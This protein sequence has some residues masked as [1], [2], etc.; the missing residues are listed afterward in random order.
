DLP[1]CLCWAN[2]NWSRRWDGL[3]SQILIGQNHSPEDD[4]AFIEHIAQYMNDKRYIRINGKPLLVIYRPSLLPDPKAT[5]TRW[6][7]WCL[8]N[9]VGE[10]Y[11]AYTQ[12]FEIAPPAKYGCDA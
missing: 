8:E 5:A 6:R 11:L 9:G 4:L 10:I 1:F 2:E 7:K 3:D 12:S